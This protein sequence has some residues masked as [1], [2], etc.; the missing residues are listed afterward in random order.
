MHWLLTF[1]LMTVS[2]GLWAAIPDL[3]C[4]ELK[5]VLLNPVTLRATEVTESR[6]LYRFKT[7]ELFLSNPDVK[8][9]R[10]NKVVQQERLRFTVGHKTLLFENDF[11]RATFVHVYADEVRISHASCNKT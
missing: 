4:Q 7:G 6:T 5:V 3:L 2:P 11:R 10:Y 1:A 9:Y 8:E